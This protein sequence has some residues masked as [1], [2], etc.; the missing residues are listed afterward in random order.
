[1]LIPTERGADVV[2]ELPFAESHNEAG[3]A[4]S[5]VSCQNHFVHALWVTVWLRWNLT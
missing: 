1:M 4:D 2:D 3:F 5:G